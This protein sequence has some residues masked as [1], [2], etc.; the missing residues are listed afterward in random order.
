VCDGLRVRQV[1]SRLLANAIG[2]TT[3]GE[4]VI[5]LDTAPGWL[6]LHVADTGPGISA[7]RQAQLLPQNT[8]EGV[9][10]LSGGLGLTLAHALARHMGGTLTLES[11]PGMGTRFTLSLPMPD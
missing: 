11:V 10:P 5:E 6:R 3:Q 2:Y 7:E 8:A 9:Q 1:L 4:V